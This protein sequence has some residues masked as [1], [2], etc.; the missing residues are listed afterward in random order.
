M[1]KSIYIF[2]KEICFFSVP[3]IVL[4]VFM[5]YLDP[6]N[7][8][9]QEQNSELLK[10]KQ[11]ISSK[12]NYPLYGIQKYYNKPTDAI[13]LG[14]SRANSLNEVLFL[15]LTNKKSTNL[16][17]GGGSIQE[18]IDTFWIVSK[19]HKPREVYIGINFNLYNELN[20]KN[21]VEEANKIRNSKISYLL[22]KYCIKSTF[23]I[24]KSMITNK[25]ISL[26]RPPM[27]RREFWN[28]QLSISGP[29]FYEHYIYPA[30]YFKELQS[31]TDYCKK[32]KI[33]LIFFI[34]P[35]HI[36]LQLKV[37]EYKLGKEYKRFIDDLVSLNVTLY[38]FDFPNFMTMN[39]NNFRDPFHCNSS[40]S[41]IIINILNGDNRFLTSYN[42][43]YRRYN[44]LNIPDN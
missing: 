27:S 29:M 16:A 36:D 26:E 38:D 42:K 3:F 11:Q 18:I 22:S 31:I 39:K 8:L 24:L 32:N 30:L 34:P 2:I 7:I 41:E 9:R 17:Y 10:L 25:S 4:F 13:I 12:V 43:I 14:D 23:L 44:G 28:Y 37:K 5:I 33:K 1:K 19:I 6:Y 40:Y 21:R 15:K 20:N 35:T